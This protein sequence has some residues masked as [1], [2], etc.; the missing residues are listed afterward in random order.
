M[1][2][3]NPICAP[4]AAL[5]SLGFGGQN[6]ARHGTY[7]ATPSAPR[8]GES[9]KQS[10]YSEGE[11]NY[12]AALAI[13]AGLINGQIIVNPTDA[14]RVL[15]VAIDRLTWAGPRFSRCDARRYDLEEGK[16]EIHEA[17]GFLEV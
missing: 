1:A 15:I 2:V 3:S 14:R 7:Q 9:P 11:I 16:R 8:V 10:G 6:E 4:I 17:D 12:N 13:K 5:A